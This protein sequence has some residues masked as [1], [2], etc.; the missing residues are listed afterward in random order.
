MQVLEKLS[1]VLPGV[2]VHAAALTFVQQTMGPIMAGVAS[3]AGLVLAFVGYAQAEEVP[4]A[5][6]EAIDTS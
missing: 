4:E 3:T 1:W 5:G 2:L 6:G